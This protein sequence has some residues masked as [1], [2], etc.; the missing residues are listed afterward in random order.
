MGDPIKIHD[1]AKKMIQLAGLIPN[2]DIEI[3]FVGM[4][5]GEKLYEELYDEYAETVPT[6]HQKILKVID[7][8]PDHRHVLGQ[9]AHLMQSLQAGDCD[10]I[11]KNIKEMVPEYHSAK[12][13]IKEGA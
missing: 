13:E 12:H 5:P 7:R 4:R 1:L 3:K 9:L 6:H 8:V 10:S 2:H 11:V